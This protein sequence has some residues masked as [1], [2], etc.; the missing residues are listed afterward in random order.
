MSI[1]T[2]VSAC[3][4]TEQDVLYGVKKEQE[5]NVLTTPRPDIYVRDLSSRRCD[6]GGKSLTVLS[7]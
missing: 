2:A 6:D 7:E 5:L 1:I 4:E 3:D